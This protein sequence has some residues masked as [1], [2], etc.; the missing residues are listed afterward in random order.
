MK[1]SPIW[2]IVLLSIC[3]LTTHSLLGKEFR[4][5]TYNVENL[6]DGTHHMAPDGKPLDDWPYTPLNF[7]GKNE[8]CTDSIMARGNPHWSE[9]LRHKL[10]TD[11]IRSDYNEAKFQLKLDHISQVITNKGEE[12]LPDIIA[13]TEITSHK[14]VEALAHKLQYDSFYKTNNTSTTRG[15]NVAIMFNSNNENLKI[16]SLESYH[17]PSQKE[18][19]DVLG[20]LF[21]FNGQKIALLVAHWPAPYNP[22]EERAQIS[23]FMLNKAIDLQKMGYKVILTGDFNTTEIEEKHYNEV[24]KQSG[25]KD[26]FDYAQTMGMNLNAPGSHFFKKDRQWNRLDHIYFSN[27]LLSEKKFRFFDLMVRDFASKIYQE[28]KIPFATNLET[29]SEDAFG[30]SDHFPMQLILDL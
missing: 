19:R 6:F 1:G 8:G 15:L 16:L 29:S 2:K 12:P 18:F 5:M 3:T 4:L 27:S 21:D 30:F 28:Q 10:Y 17:L 14:S 11:C 13:L 9:G 7:A 20:A 24:F 23:E 22:K 26:S 25:F